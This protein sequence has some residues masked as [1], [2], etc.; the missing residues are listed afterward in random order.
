MSNARGFWVR[1]RVAAGYP[2]AIACFW[3]AK[4]T[5]TS[6]E[7]GAAVAIAGLIVRAL[8]AGVVRK[9]EELT[10]SGIYSWTRNPLYFGSIMLA[11]G[12]VVASR[13]WIVAALAAAYLAVFYPIVIRN[14]ERFLR[15]RF[16]AQFDSYVAQV[17]VFLPWPS[18]RKGNGASFSFAQWAR[19]HEYRALIGAA[20]GF[21]LM[22]FRMW[23]RSR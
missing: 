5:W 23:L 10:T 4:P 13:S 7:Y 11:A 20:V 18:G 16:G 2:F 8:A 17:S 1:W 19:N 14:E 21:A 6:L 3:L 22:I 15:E 12:I 9:R